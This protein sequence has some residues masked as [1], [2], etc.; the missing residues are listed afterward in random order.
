MLEQE[1]EINRMNELTLSR[2]AANDAMAK[3]FME[4][5]NR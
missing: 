5:D 2:V 1:L 3:S 4:T